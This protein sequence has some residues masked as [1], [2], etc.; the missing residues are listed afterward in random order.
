MIISTQPSNLYYSGE[1]YLATVAKSQQPWLYRIKAP[2][3]AGVTVAAG[4]DTPVVTCDPL[5]G[6]CSAVTR[7]AESGQVLLPE[8]RL[9][10]QQ[11]LALFT[12]NAAYADFSEG[13]KGSLA[14][15]KLA[16]LV[17]L[18]DDPARVPPEEIKDI[19]VEMTI[20]GGK[21]VYER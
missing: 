14:P 8:E 18:S 11:A 19:K 7:Q 6:I 17:V 21:I 15:G 2:M 10:P 9:T 3:K 12:I 16:D 5:T 13:I 4:S 1:R 20:I